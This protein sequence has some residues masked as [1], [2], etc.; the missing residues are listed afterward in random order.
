[1][2][3]LSNY[4][5]G[6]SGNEPEIAGQPEHYLKCNGCGEVFSDLDVAAQ[7]ALDG[8]LGELDGPDTDPCDNTWEIVPEG[9]AF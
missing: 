5:P 1:M 8:L 7:H 3:G 2:S 6:V 4:P 9:V